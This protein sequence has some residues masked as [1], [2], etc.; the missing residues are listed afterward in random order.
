MCVK[1]KEEL[2]VCRGKLKVVNVSHNVLKEFNGSPC[3]IKIL[4]A[5]CS[6][7]CTPYLQ[8]VPSFTQ[9]NP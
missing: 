3:R 1:K 4:P 7:E 8:K 9:Q 2:E 6:V 5:P